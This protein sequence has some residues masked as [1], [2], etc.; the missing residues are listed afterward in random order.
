MWPHFVEGPS[1]V[2]L[3]PNELMVQVPLPQPS[4]SLCCHLFPAQK[5]RITHSRKTNQTKV[6]PN[7]GHQIHQQTQPALRGG[8]GNSHN[9]IAPR[10]N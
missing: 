2:L 3:S 9:Y 1:Q 4:R 8:G 5:T 10:E 6:L 7:R